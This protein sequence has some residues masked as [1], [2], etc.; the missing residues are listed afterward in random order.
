[1]KPVLQGFTDLVRALIAAVL[2][3]VLVAGFML[4]FTKP[5]HAQQ[6]CTYPTTEWHEP[7]QQCYVPCKE[8]EIR[9]E[10]GRCLMPI[11]PAYH[12]WYPELGY[13]V[14][15]TP[16]NCSPGNP[17][18]FEPAR[19]PADLIKKRGL[20]CRAVRVQVEPHCLKDAGCEVDQPKAL[21][22]L[23]TVVMSCGK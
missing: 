15:I 2:L 5:A 12:V 10:E 21:A 23:L 16:P 22:L 7:T 1:M 18:E 17:C 19:A 3:V 20:S 6:Q 4:V 8:G 11:C 14:P 9:N 13:C